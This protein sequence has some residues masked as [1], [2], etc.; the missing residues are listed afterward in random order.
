MAPNEDLGQGVVIVGAGPVGLVLAICLGRA[1]V[2]CTVLEA[3]AVAPPELRA[4]TF[5][6]PTLDMLDGLGLTPSL[7]AAGLKAP[8]W[9]V[10]WHETGE[11]AVFDLGL[12][13]DDTA[14]PYRLQCPQDELVRVAEGMARELPTV[15]VLRGA[16]VQG[17][18][19]QDDYVVVSYDVDGRPER[20][21]CSVLVGADG[22][23]SVVRGHVSERFDGETYPETT[24]LATTRFPFQQH[25]PGLSN[26]NY[27]WWEEGTFSL[28]ALPGLW[29]VNFHMPEGTDLDAA[30]RPEAIQALLE[31]L[32]PGSGSSP[33]EECRQYRIHRRIVD[34][35]RC[36]RVV[37]A[38]DAAHLN[39]PAGGMGMN[40]GIHD[41]FELACTLLEIRDGAALEL[42]DRYER[43]RLP[44][45]RDDIQRQ[46]DANRARMQARDA[47]A[48]RAALSALQATA[49]DPVMAREHLLRSSMISGLRAT[50]RVD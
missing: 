6:P 41:A 27:L 43:R 19:P 17:I 5:H 39:S 11:A 32:V 29:R 9:Q 47:T 37:L 13:K 4:S 23:R 20:Q 21:S 1:G 7:L 12:L 2:S 44:I 40:G 10:R 45:A 36:G 18:A 14:H 25:L 38:G 28:L 24:L 31:R 48:R 26:V 35:Y 22:A 3:A 33:V 16:R 42:L 50:A 46:S 34:R 8:T 49:A 30:C 15:R